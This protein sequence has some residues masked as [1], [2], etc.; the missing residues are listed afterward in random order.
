MNM[1]MMRGIGGGQ[2]PDFSAMKEKMF[3]KADSNDDKAISF[4]EFQSAGKNMPM[5][6]TGGTD[7]AK[8]AF[9]KIDSDGNGSLSRDEM[10]ALGDKMS[11]QMQGMM[12]NMQSM[13]GGSG[14]PDLNAMFGRADGDKNGGIS[15]AE[16]DKARENSPMAGLLDQGDSDEA[17]GKIDSDG[18]G[19]L[20]KDEVSAFTKEMKEKMH[21]MMGGGGQQAEFMQAMNAYR[22]GSGSGSTDL[23]QKFL[24]M[25]DG[26]KSKTDVTA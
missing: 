3:Q 25:L 1:S 14:G 20:S 26:A 23:T 9:G 17:F 13:M 21:Q 10:S 8:E 18:D 19:S 24:Q 4:E 11:S 22:K 7:K 6:K 15:R 2:M 12:L 5:G 16:F